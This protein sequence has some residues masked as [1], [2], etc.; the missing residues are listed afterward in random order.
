MTS[1]QVESRFNAFRTAVAVGIALVLAAVLIFWTSDTPIEAIRV[2]VVGPLENV[3][4]MGNV[5]ELMF[6]LIMGGCAISIMYSAN[7]FSQIVP[8][9]FFLGGLF[10]T[11]VAVYVPMPKGI[12]GT[13]SLIVAGMAG[14][15]LSAIPAFMKYKWQASE[16]VSSLMLQ[17]I[18]TYLINYMLVYPMKDYSQGYTCSHPYLETAKLTQFVPGTRIHTGIFWVIG[19][20]IL[21]YLFLFKSKW[22]YA[23]R[24]VGQNQ[25]FARYSGIAVGAVMVYSQV[26][27]GFIA[28][29]AGS[30]EL[31]GLTHRMTWTAAPSYASDG[32]MVG[33]LAGYNP[34][35]IPFSA[36]FMA[37]MRTGVDVMTRVTD[38]PI[39]FVFI[40]Q[41]IVVMM[42]A[43]EMF[44]FKW[45]RKLIIANAMKLEAAKEANK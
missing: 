1:K 17:Y 18:V 37:Y 21:S 20:V 24:V 8:S 22:G 42:I 19:T 5:I 36:L 13:V 11:I 44:L 43:A 34:L 41:G 39:E 27:G 33:I 45:K 4:R 14:A 10:G 28:G 40:I 23:L 9:C 3:R 7:Q 38:M 32:M 12:H 2:F 16:V 26:I 25:T 29:I 35:F 30:I 15:A 6:P 31:L